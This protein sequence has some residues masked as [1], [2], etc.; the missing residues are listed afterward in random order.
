MF[1]LDVNHD[2]LFTRIFACSHLWRQLW[3][4]LRNEHGRNRVSKATRKWNKQTES[5]F[6]IS[7]AT[8]V[9]QRRWE[10][11][12]VRIVRKS[13][14][15]MSLDRIKKFSVTLKR[16]TRAKDWPRRQSPLRLQHQR[17][18]IRK[19]SFCSDNYLC[20]ASYRSC[21]IF[22]SF[23]MQQFSFKWSDGIQ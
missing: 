6:I 8:R 10:N 3:P 9:W 19:I 23:G 1:Y 17:T 2:G 21:L 11:Q 4:S 7:L 5:P 15:C 20:Y 22:L 14:A 12:L 13:A 16:Q 18:L